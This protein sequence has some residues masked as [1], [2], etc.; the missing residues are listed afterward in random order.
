MKIKSILGFCQCKGC[1]KRY[2]CEAELKFHV[3]AG[4]MR[5]QKL[6]LCDYIMSRDDNLEPLFIT[7]NKYRDR[8]GILRYRRMPNSA[9]ENLTKSIGAAAGI[10]DKKCTVHAFRKTFATRM[11]ERDCPIEIVQELLGHADV[12]TTIRYYVGKSKVRANREFDR[13]MVSA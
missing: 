3:K 12:G 4:G 5:T 8:D 2:V 7:K 10:R 11:A 13:C 9:Y 1:R 6:R